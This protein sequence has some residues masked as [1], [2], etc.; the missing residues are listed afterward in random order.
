MKK[1]C[2]LLSCIL[3]FQLLIGCS[4]KE[5]EIL[6]PVNFYYIN[7]EISY[8]T[9]NGVVQ[10][11]IRE[12]AEFRD[13]EE[14]LQVYLKGPVASELR[15]FMPLGVK[16]LSCVVDNDSIYILLSS[17]FAKLSGVK[18]TTACSAIL[19]TTHDYLGINTLYVRVEGSQLDDKDTFILAMDDLVLSDS[20][21][22]EVPKE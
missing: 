13:I 15:S 14:L 20:V 10:A 11:E 9:P 16:L 12:G 19:M 5:E 4:R 1:I 7:S 17:Q 2:W 22:S 21:S 6:Q 3:L 18:L 8:N